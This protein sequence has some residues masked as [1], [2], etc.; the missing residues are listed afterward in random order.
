M[1]SYFV[2]SCVRVTE[3]LVSIRE[4]VLEA[5]PC[6]VALMLHRPLADIASE[7]KFFAV[8]CISNIQF[9]L[10]SRYDLLIH[11]FRAS[12]LLH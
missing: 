9:G 6:L 2:N 10:V 5:A 4:V 8:T 3:I 12:H 7:D 11:R 1:E